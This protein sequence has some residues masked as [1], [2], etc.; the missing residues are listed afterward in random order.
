MAHS[1]FIGIAD[2]PI[3]ALALLR[4]KRAKL[5]LLCTTR[6]QAINILNGVKAAPPRKGPL[7][8]KP[9]PVGAA[10]RCRRCKMP[11]Q[12]GEL[13]STVGCIDTDQHIKCTP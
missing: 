6:K 10:G 12:W 1:T 3:I 8:I 13:C 5:T 2:G 7:N 4:L 9:V 11:I